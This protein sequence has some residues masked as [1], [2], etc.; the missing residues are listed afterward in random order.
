MSYILLTIFLSYL[1]LH[2]KLFYISFAI[3]KSFKF[4][5]KYHKIQR[6]H[7]YILAHEMN[8]FLIRL[9]LSFTM[10]V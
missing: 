6:K 2:M 7:I 10:K 8:K 9:S 5:Q 1:K 3:N 4:E